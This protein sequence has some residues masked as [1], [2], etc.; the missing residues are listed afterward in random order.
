MENTCSFYTIYEFKLSNG[1]LILSHQPFKS[2]A[3]R[4]SPYKHHL[5][6]H[7]SEYP[8]KIQILTKCHFIWLQH[9]QITM[10]VKNKQQQ[11]RKTAENRC[12][13]LI[14]IYQSPNYS[15]NMHNVSCEHADHYR[16]HSKL[17]HKIILLLPRICAPISTLAHTAT[18]SSIAVNC[19]ANTS[20]TPRMAKMWNEIA[21]KSIHEDNSSHQL[22]PEENQELNLL[23]HTPMH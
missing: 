9:N 13:Q 14:I 11:Q 5:F 8:S 17:L 4:W 10:N 7:N 23:L 1:N 20:S 16:S 21:P 6:N 22:W 15:T 12:N 19:H 3:N 2:H 18:I